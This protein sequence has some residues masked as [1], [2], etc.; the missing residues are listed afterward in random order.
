MVLM[1]VYQAICD[2]KPCFYVLCRG[3]H[4]RNTAE[5]GP[6]EIGKIESKGRQNRRVIIKFL[7]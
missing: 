1:M 2:A 6:V 3:T 5:I 4:V 7:A